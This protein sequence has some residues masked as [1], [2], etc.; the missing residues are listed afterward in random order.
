MSY[1]LS[2]LLLSC[3][4]ADGV[5]LDKGKIRSWSMRV[6]V[7]AEQEAF[8]SMERRIEIAVRHAGRLDRLLNPLQN[9]PH[10]AIRADLQ[11]LLDVLVEDQ[12]DLHLAGRAVVAARGL[13]SKALPL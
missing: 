13:L 8:D 3:L 11:N 7:V 10:H 6:D 5:S 12:S 2:R 4:L 1:W 9:A